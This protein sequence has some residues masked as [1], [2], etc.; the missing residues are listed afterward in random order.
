MR[1]ETYDFGPCY[2]AWSPEF[3]PRSTSTRSS[4]PGSSSDRSPSPPTH[5]AFPTSTSP[6]TPTWL[7]EEPRLLPFGPRFLERRSMLLAHHHVHTQPLLSIPERS[8]TAY[9][10]SDSYPE[11]TGSLPCSSTTTSYCVYPSR[12][13]PCRVS[14]A[15]APGNYDDG[16]LFSW[17]TSTT[18]YDRQPDSPLQ[19]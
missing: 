19:K 1:K 6:K 17:W 15:I 12:S 14:R 13:P 11:T 10:T 2:P 7:P 5:K 9:S 16:P 18:D 3:Y 8:R 4:R